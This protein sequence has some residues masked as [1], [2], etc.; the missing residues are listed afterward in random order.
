[1]E[2]W[3]S[4]LEGNLEAKVRSRIIGCKAQMESFIFFYGINLGITIY[5]TTDNLSKALQAESI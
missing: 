2:I 3:E 1:M 4:C 5:S